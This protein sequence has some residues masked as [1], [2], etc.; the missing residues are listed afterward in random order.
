MKR[1]LREI[2][3]MRDGYADMEFVGDQ[4]VRVKI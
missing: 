1:T 2:T 3:F 4:V